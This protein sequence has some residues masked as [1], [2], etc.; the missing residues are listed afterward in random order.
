MY[1][2]L[3]GSIKI[4]AAT[5]VMMSGLLT[6]PLMEREWKLVGVALISASASFGEMTF[7]SLTGTYEDSTVG[8]Y[9]AGTGLSVLAANLYY[10]G[11]LYILTWI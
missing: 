7:L 3:G 11:K 10:L 1:F 6:V 4:C 9:C 5:V 2:V 8:S